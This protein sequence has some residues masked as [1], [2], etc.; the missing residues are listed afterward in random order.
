MT[1]ESSK[2]FEQIFE[3]LETI[4]G[5]MEKGDLPLQE[6][7]QLFE[8]G[9]RLSREGA[10]RLNDAEQTI[11]RLLRTEEQKETVVPWEE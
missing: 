7:L 11:E 3:Q 6:S 1:N 5:R 10:L 8:E 9:I 4:V 2:S